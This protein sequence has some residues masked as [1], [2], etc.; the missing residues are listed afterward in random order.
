M[1]KMKNDYKEIKWLYD[2]R[3]LIPSTW[4]K[5][6]LIDAAID[7]PQYGA[8]VAAA[9]FNTQLPRYVRITDINSNGTLKNNDLRSISITESDEYILSEN[10]IVFARTGSVGR[11]YLHNKKNGLCAFA[12]YLIRFRLDHNIIDPVFLFHYTHSNEYWRW[13]M[14]IH[15]IG[16]QPNVNARLYSNMPIIIPQVNEQKKIASILSSVDALIES[17]SQIIKQNKILKKSLLQQFLNNGIFHKKLKKNDW[18]FNRKIELPLDWNLQTIDNSFKFLKTGSNP[19]KDLHKTGQIQYIHYGDI[20]TKWNTIV[21]CNTAQIPY[22]D[23]HK[24]KNLTLLKNNDLIISDVSEDYVGSGSSI[25][26]K[27][28][29]Q[30]K[31]V[32]GLHTFALRS[33]IILEPDFIKYLTSINIVK[34]QIVSYVTGTSVYGIS[35]SNLKKVMIPV[36]P[37][38]EQQKIASILSNVDVYIVKNQEYKEKLERLKKSLMQKLFSGQIRVKI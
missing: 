35:K 14:H 16:V 5:I 13:L 10:D 11:T 15:T 4:K 26:L 20:H 37:I 27:N 33:K 12:S 30:R 34:Q 2:T 8:N 22:I 19:R 31:I 7:K 24:I 38:N 18:L 21:D 9:P 1:T 17:I 36:P 29:D 23:K 6:K 25:L 28:V 32:S 3:M